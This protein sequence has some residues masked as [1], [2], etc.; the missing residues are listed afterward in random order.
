MP[1]DEQLRHDLILVLD[2]AEREP[3]REFVGFKW[4]RD[5]PLAQA[6]FAWAAEAAA[7]QSALT[8][9]IQDGLIRTGKR[10]NPHDPQ[11][12]TTSISL[13]RSDP[14]VA[15]YLGRSRGRGPVRPP[16]G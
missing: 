16:L 13:N 11:F 15:A 2:R 10:L 12:G 1:L 3:G 7:R 6:G 14:R 8:L 5:I 4:F 9:A